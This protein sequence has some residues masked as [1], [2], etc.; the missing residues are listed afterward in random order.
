M[1]QLGAAVGFGLGL[2]LHAA[3]ATQETGMLRSSR[4]R[5]QLF[6]NQLTPSLSAQE[7]FQHNLRRVWQ[8]LVLLRLLGLGLIAVNGALLAWAE[9]WWWSALIA[10][11]LVALAVVLADAL[12]RTLA[13][14]WPDRA[15]NLCSPSLRVQH[16]LLSTV[17]GW[18]MGTRSAEGESDAAPRELPPGS[19]AVAGLI[20]QAP[21]LDSPEASVSPI[22]E[23]GDE[24]FS[25]ALDFNLTRVGAFMVPRT[26]IV[27]MPLSSTVDELKRRFVETKLSRIVVYRDTL[28]EL[29]G[30]V[31]SSA[32]LEAEAPPTALE[33][34]IQPLLAVPETLPANQ[35]LREF[36]R[37]RKSI[38]AVVDEFGGTAGLVTLEDLVEVIVGEI[39][40]EYDEPK[41]PDRV[42]EPLGPEAWRLSARLEIEYLNRTYALELPEGEYTTLGG[43]V[44]Q[45]AERIPEVGESFVA[46]GLR[47]TVLS[48]TPSRVAVVKV[49]R[50]AS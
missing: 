50:V 47:L 8:S 43:Y 46:E 35:L 32:L 3:V 33:P 39:D 22:P 16:A 19:S 24:V 38:A 15:L 12:P 2:A 44:L 20:A 6:C 29:V 4:L 5:L 21:H 23:L 37:H 26:E 31:H 48:A 42:E 18:L 10:L 49:E 41:D 7:T 9:P 34:L 14:R 27:A 1:L 28:D 17:A 40:D 30:I 25:A 13:R 36:N 45:L 11:G